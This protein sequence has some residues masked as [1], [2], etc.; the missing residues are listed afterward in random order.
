M[1]QHGA[2]CIGLRCCAAGRGQRL[3]PWA[4]HAGAGLVRGVDV[5]EAYSNI[6]ARSGDRRFCRVCELKNVEPSS[7]MCGR[8]AYVRRVCTQRSSHTATQNTNLSSHS[9]SAPH[10]R[11]FLNPLTI[12]TPCPH[13]GAAQ[14]QPH[15]ISK[16]KKN[17][18]HTKEESE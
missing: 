13:A 8:I 14:L 15:G 4:A 2:A 18:D 3:L 6:M 16:K 17:A 1:Q 12:K 5:C 11:Q 7:C 9:L 10:T